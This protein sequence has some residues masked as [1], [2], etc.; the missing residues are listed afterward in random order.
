MNFF[1]QKIKTFIK[2]EKFV[3]CF[4]DNGIGMSEEYLKHIF[5]RF[6]RERNT[7]ESGIEGTGLGLSIARQIRPST[8]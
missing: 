4:S 3:L 8:Y 1:L 5:E 2:D 6:S 7:T